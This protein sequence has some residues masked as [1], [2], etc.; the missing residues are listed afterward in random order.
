MREKVVKKSQSLLRQRIIQV[1]SGCPRTVRCGNRSQSL[2]RQRIIQV[3][4]I[5]P[6]MPASGFSLNRFFVSES[7]RSLAKLT[8]A[9]STAVVSIASS[10][11][12]HSGHTSAGSA[13]PGYSWSQS[14]LRQRIIQVGSVQ[15]RR[16]AP[17]VVSIA[18]S[19]ANHSGHCDCR[20]HR[21]VS[22]RVS[23]ASSSANHSGRFS[24]S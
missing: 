10:S 22:R 19:S 18:S 16:E 13:S 7:F 8:G 20:R 4:E 12:N 11:A 17:Q 14:L 24:R 9:P 23:I 21:F 15:R 1:V 3:I 6:E 5:T 2:L